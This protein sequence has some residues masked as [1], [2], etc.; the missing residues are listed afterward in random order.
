MN[1][2]SACSDS[3]YAF[4]VNLSY[5]RINFLQYEPC[6]EIFVK[7]NK[8]HLYLW[9]LGDYSG[10]FFF[11]NSFLSLQMTLRNRCSRSARRKERCSAMRK[12]TKKVITLG[13]MQLIRKWCHPTV[14][15]RNWACRAHC[16][17]FVQP[18]WASQCHNWFSSSHCDG[19][20]R[21]HRIGDNTPYRK[22][23]CWTEWWR[24]QAS[25]LPRLS[26]KRCLMFF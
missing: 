2:Y 1:F 18:F 7:M 26:C 23:S 5:L 22:Q 10:L 9:C 15:S 3:L 25:S 8:P 11:F 14:N 13:K 21:L 17:C 12:D 4:C 6:V 16:V 20:I 19:G 24:T